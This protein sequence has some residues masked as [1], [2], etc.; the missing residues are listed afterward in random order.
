MSKP[1]SGNSELNDYDGSE[2][3][4]FTTKSWKIYRPEQRD[5][6]DIQHPAKFPEELAADY[7]EFFTQ[8]GDLVLDPF[9]GTGSAIQAAEDLG[10]RGI[11]VELNEEYARIA[12]RKLTPEYPTEIV[13]GDA[14]EWVETAKKGIRF[15]DPMGDPE[16]PEFDFIITSPPYWNVLQKSRG[17]ADTAQKKRER[18]GLDTVYSDSTRDLGNIDDYEVFIR[19]LVAFFEG[20]DSLITDGGYLA[21]VTQNVRAEDGEVRPIAYD[22][23]TRLRDTY[24]LKG[25]RIW[26]QD[27]KPS[28]IW[29]YPTEY[30][31]GKAHHI[32]NVFK[33]RDGD[34]GA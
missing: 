19:E 15:P 32:I 16:P 6:D 33:K 22:L 8:T 9:A 13:N 26:L 17:G 4:K 5:S 29:G 10:R 12:R 24:E 7:I 34:G 30:V 14:R 1:D 2:W 25:E 31:S 28:A 18:E 27:D 20:L 23:G 3:V 11:G 21:I